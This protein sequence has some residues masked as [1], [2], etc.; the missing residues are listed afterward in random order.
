MPIIDLLLPEFDHETANT[1]KMLERV[2]DDKFGWKPHAKSLDL[3]ALAS[4]VA[5]NTHWLAG[6]LVSESFDL[7]PPGKPPYNPPRA[8]STAELLAMFDKSA[9]EARA[10]LAAATD[11]QL[12]Q[13]W[14]LLAGG[15]AVF[16]MPRVA[17]YR[18][19]VMNHL[20]HHRGQLSV[21]LRLLDVLIPGMYGP[22]ADD[23]N[24]MA[25]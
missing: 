4:H 1:R 15:H 19:M 22:S 10:A 20:I 13:P 24:P 2:P 17:C 8:K 23:P 16:T 18:G 21:Y 6:M 14:S 7:M 25:G 9:A 12:C 3:C 11:E 5:T